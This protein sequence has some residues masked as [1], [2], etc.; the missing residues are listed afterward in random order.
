[1]SINSKILL[2]KVSA[3]TRVDS[4]ANANDGKNLRNSPTL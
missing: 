4:V 2:D 1:M 3:E